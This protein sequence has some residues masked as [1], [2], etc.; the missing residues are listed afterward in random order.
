ML[1]SESTLFALLTI[2][3]LGLVVPEMFKRFKI[4]F[5][6]SIILVG[7]VLGPNLLGYVESNEVINFFGFLGMTF[8]MLMAGLETDLGKIGHLKA[9]V[10]V[11][12]AFNIL[13]PLLVGLAISSLFGYS[14]VD[15][16][17]V[18][19][20]FI[21]SSVVMVLP[22]LK[23]AGVLKKDLGQA[24]ISSIMIADAVGLVLFTVVLQSVSPLAKLP[25][26][27]HFLVL[28]VSVTAIFLIIPKLIRFYTNK[29]TLANV[30]HETQLRFIMVI[31]IA[32]LAYFSF[33]GV[34]AILAAFIVGVALSR[35]IRSHEIYLKFHTLGYGLFVPIFFFVVGMEMDFAVFSL[36]NSAGLVVVSIVLGSILS[37]F[38]SGFIGGKIANFS[39]VNAS[40]FGTASMIHLTTALAITFTASS[41]NILDPVLVT[42]MIILSIVTTILGPLVLR[43]FLNLDFHKK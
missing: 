38:I 22:V 15:S 14:L 31:T 19:I 20:I 2:L 4:P 29:K 23:S 1:A 12:S 41:L 26:P 34:H 36:A 5:V 18:G 9:K 27:L 30:E 8:I 21:S 40:V 11:M 43:L 39:T 33:L 42:S 7:A 3:T 28:A 25:L 37:K 24:I 10:A 17:I 6:T 16:I 32:V 35:T 13:V